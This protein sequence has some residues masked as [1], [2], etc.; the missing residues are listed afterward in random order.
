MHFSVLDPGRVSSCLVIPS[1]SSCKLSSLDPDTFLAATFTFLPPPPLPPMLFLPQKRRKLGVF[2]FF[3]HLLKTENHYT[4]A[5]GKCTRQCSR[6]R[7]YS[8]ISIKATSSLFFPDETSS[9]VWEGL[10]LRTLF[11]T[12]GFDCSWTQGKQP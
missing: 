6:H 9:S 12:M 4:T 3:S 1:S 11:G 5:C 2:P 10:P 7:H 8:D